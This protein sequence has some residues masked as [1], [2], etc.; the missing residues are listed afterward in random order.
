MISLRSKVTRAILAYFFT[1]DRAEAYANALARQLELDP[2]NVHSKLIQLESEG[3]L[4]SRFGGKERFFS[5]NRAF[6][7]LKEYRAIVEKTVGVE[8]LL[9][10]ALAGVKDITE[11]YLFGSF[12][13][14]TSDPKSDIDVLAI[15]GHSALDLE[16]RLRPLKKSLGRQINVVSLS[17]EEFKKRRSGKDPFLQDIMRSKHVRIV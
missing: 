8:F 2:K 7:L 6:P 15:G 3:L 10:E 11:G 17:E 13:K 16:R 5:L 12:A 9:R 14:G 4:K 1:N